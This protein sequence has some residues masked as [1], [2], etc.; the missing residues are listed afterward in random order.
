ME[1][2]NDLGKLSFDDLP[3]EVD[4]DFTAAEQLR[5]LNALPS[6]IQGLAVSWGTNDTPF[7]DNV[8]EFLIKNQFGLSCSEYYA[9]KNI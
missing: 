3:F 1:Q 4:R 6:H 8:F 9:K 7:I 2:F 5:I